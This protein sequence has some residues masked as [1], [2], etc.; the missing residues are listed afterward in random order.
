M[1]FQRALALH[2]AILLKEG[3]AFDASNRQVAAGSP[4]QVEGIHRAATASDMYQ[5]LRQDS[6][7]VVPISSVARPGHVMEGTR[8]TLVKASRT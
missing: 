7:L 5:V 6:W 2:K 8:L 4:D 3:H 1:N